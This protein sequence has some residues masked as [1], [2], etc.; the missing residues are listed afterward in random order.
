MQ[1]L[2][3]AVDS[4]FGRTGKG[5]A[6]VRLDRALVSS[7]RLSIVTMLLTEAVRLQFAVQAFDDA[8]CRQYSRSGKWGS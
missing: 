8:E 2:G 1:I 5:S 3:V 7:C 4:Y 6:M